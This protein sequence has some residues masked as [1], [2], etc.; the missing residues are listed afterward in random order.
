MAL[1]SLVNS[2]IPTSSGKSEQETKLHEKP[3]AIHQKDDR[4][5][6]GAEQWNVRTGDR[7]ED[8]VVTTKKV[9]NPSR[10][11]VSISHNLEN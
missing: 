4:N 10:I 11:E 7:Q 5:H 8:D 1:G 2:G 6:P 3:I 9:L